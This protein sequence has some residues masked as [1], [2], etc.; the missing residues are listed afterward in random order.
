MVAGEPAN[1]III[2]TNAKFPIA[3]FGILFLVDEREYV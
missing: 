1:A 3:A 2:L